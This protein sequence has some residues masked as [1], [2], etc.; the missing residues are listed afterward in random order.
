MSSL[1]S[2]SGPRSHRTI[3]FAVLCIVLLL[4]G[5]VVQS[6]HMHQDGTTHSDC[7]LCATAHAAVSV[8]AFLALFLLLEVVP[9]PS[10]CRTE[11]FEHREVPFALSNRPPPA[12]LA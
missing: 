8:A 3:V 1:R 7:A 11:T 12:D 9:T 2:R 6:A 5:A 4:L 10:A